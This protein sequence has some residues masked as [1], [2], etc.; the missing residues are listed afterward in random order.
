MAPR[1]YRR[2]RLTRYLTR[3]WRRYNED[4][5]A[6]LRATDLVDLTELPFSEI[7]RDGVVYRVHG[8]AHDQP[9]FG[10]R[11]RPEVREA[12]VRFI[13]AFEGPNEGYVL[14]AGFGKSLGLPRDREVR[15][16]TNPLDALTPWEAVRFFVRILATIALLPLVP[17]LFRVSGGPGIRELWGSL[18]DLRR[19]PRGRKL[20]QLTELPEP[21]A[22]ELEAGPG[23]R[24]RWRM[25]ELM[26]KA[27]SERAQREGWT[28][29]HCVCGFA[30]EAQIALA[31]SGNG[32]S[33]WLPPSAS[34]PRR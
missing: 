24:V 20:Y 13:T 30:H 34:R 12:I 29:V 17:F 5:I 31:L 1:K 19:L 2:K 21:L 9:R 25:S 32:P 28:I 27:M 6:S 3:E 10:V 33:S 23:A 7:E 16:G 8:I 15:S 14:E 18:R 26:A 4:A 22:T 11:M